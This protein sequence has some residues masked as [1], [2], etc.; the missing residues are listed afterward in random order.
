MEPVLTA[1]HGARIIPPTV[2][3]G[4]ITLF[5]IKSLDGMARTESAVTA[6][7]ILEHDREYAL[8]DEAGRWVN[9]KRTPKIQ[10]LRCAY[11]PEVREVSL[12]EQ[13]QTVRTTF[14]LVD[15]AA[16]GRWLS[17]FFSFAVTVRHEPRGGFPDDAEAFG[18]TVVSEAS[19]RAVAA[20]FPGLDLE[21]ARRRFRANLEIAGADAFA[22]DA[23]YGGPDERR[24]FTIGTVQLLG[25]NPCQRCVVPTRDPDTTEPIPH[26]QKIFM[27]RRE[28][29]FPAW[30]DARRFNHFYRFAVNTSISPTEAG[31]VIRV[32]DPVLC[33]PARRR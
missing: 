32:G 28:R 2:H 11:D 15:R 23:F 20:W 13:G 7:G 21:G 18:P 9:G 31:K 24:P 6:G 14:P 16:L 33:G 25:H 26:F 5:P 17:D 27:E 1:A 29:H 19:L 10:Q 22:E 3:L 4:R 30:A 12:W 8:F